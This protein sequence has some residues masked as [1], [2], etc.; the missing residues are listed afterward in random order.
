MTQRK[1]RFEPAVHLGLLVIIFVLLILNFRSNL[2]IYHAGM[3]MRRSVTMQFNSAAQSISR[4][5]QKEN[6][7]A[8]SDSRKSELVR[9]Y[10][11]SDLSYHDMSEISE[12]AWRS[13]GSDRSAFSEMDDAALAARLRQAPVKS[14][15]RGN[16]SDYFYKFVYRSSQGSRLLVLSQAAPDLAYLEDSSRTLIIVNVV[17]VVLIIILYL[18]L[19]RLILS[20]FKRI[21]RQAIDAGRAVAGEHDEVEA[22]VDD[23]HQII[24]ELKE[25]E[26]QLLELNEAIQTRAD[27]LEL[28]NQYL[29]QSMSSG[30]VMVDSFGRVMSVNKAAATIL[31]I[32]ANDATGKRVD[33]LGESLSKLFEP[34]RTLLEGGPGQSYRE[35]DT[36][37]SNN[38]VMTLGITISAVEDYSANNVGASILINDLTEIKTLRG[39]IETKN[40][41]AA[42]GEMASGLAHQLRNS[43]GAMAGYCHL[44]KKRLARHNLEL[45]SIHALEDEAREAER[46]VDRFLKFARPFDICAEA[47]DIADLVQELAETFKVR[48]ENSHI[49]FKITNRMPQHTEAEVDRL[50]VK[51][52]LANLVENAINS[53]NGNPGMILI[54]LTCDARS[55]TV[56]IADN[57]CGIEPENMEKV[58][59]PFFS[60]RPSGTGLGLPLARKIID[61]HRGRLTVTSA[62]KEGTT[63]TITLPVRQPSRTASRRQKTGAGV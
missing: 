5:V 24:D 27:N 13:D 58:F 4:T 39:E 18:V 50:L 14:L 41:L 34:V 7:D 61:L 43:I 9:K 8:L 29:L 20:P 48:P 19:F 25:K 54:G 3:E 59:T 6:L 53:Y 10:D 38:A 31:G 28:F 51:Q 60:S 30:I 36:K 49:D 46:L 2:T 22:M 56:Q 42:L 15:I 52:A 37:G 21:K 57:G 11:L 55:V 12:G 23:Y 45:D 63:F 32:D 16:E 47:T 62:P 40:R 17:A 35:Y 26:R 44:V 33:E 1:N